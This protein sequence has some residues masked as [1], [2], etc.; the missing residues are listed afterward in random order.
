MSNKN[1]KFNWVVRLYDKRATCYRKF[2]IEDRTESEAENE[3]QNDVR[4]ASDWT[5]TK[6][7]NSIVKDI[8]SR[9]WNREISADEGFEEIENLIVDK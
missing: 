1:S 3:I 2:V 6:T 9:V 7:N 4:E 5:M 8:L